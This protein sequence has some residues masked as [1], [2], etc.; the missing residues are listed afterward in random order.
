MKIKEPG[1]SL[2]IKLNMKKNQPHIIFLMSTSLLYGCSFASPV[3]DSLPSCI[4]KMKQK[5]SLLI[6]NKYDYKDQQWFGISKILTEQEMKKVNYIKTI[7]FYN[8]DCNL[9]A[10]WQTGG[11]YI[12]RVDKISPDTIDKNKIIKIT[13]EKAPEAIIKLA[14][15]NNAA[16]ITEYE[17]LGQTLYFLN[18]RNDKFNL[19]AEKKMITI[20]PYFDKNGREIIRF[21]R[22]NDPSFLRAQGWQPYTVKPEKLI[23]KGI[24][25]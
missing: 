5:D 17:Y 2:F 25:W 1:Q 9:V 22:A 18:D 11:N 21:Q 15:K 16:Y 8:S 14:I 24:I 4:L 12:K 6:V 10:T 20:K 13:G 19:N 23:K 7:I 3:I